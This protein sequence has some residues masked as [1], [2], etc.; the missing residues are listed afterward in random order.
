MELEARDVKT[1][2]DARRIVV[3]RGLTD[4]KL[5][6]TDIDGVLR[7]KYV[8]AEKF[9][10][11]LDGGFGFCDVVLGWDS[12][13]Q[14]VDNLK[15]TGWHTG[16]PDAAVRIVPE[17]CRELPLEGGGLMFLCEFAGEGAKVCPRGVLSRVVERAKGMG[18]TPYAGFEYEFF[19][20]DETPQSA[21]DKGYQNLKPIT[22]GNFG[23]SVLRNSVYAELYKDILDLGR[24]MDFPI[25]G[26]HTET[27]PGVLEAAIAVDKGMNP[28]DKAVLFKSFCKVLLNRG[29]MMPT[30]MAKY[31]NKYAGQSGH[32]HISLVD[33]AGKNVFF[34]AKGPHHMSAT[35]RHFIGGQQA[36][37]PEL[38]VMIASTVN[39]YTRLV[40]GYWAPTSATWAIDNR[41]TALRVIE[42]SQKSQ[43]VEFRVAA[44]DANPYLA[45]AAG[46]GAGLYGIENKI[47]PTAP[48]TGNAYTLPH[49]ERLAF[50]TSLGD[51]ARRFRE[52][53][54]ARAIFGEAF[55]EHFA[56]TRDWEQR[57]FQ[58]AVT[59]WE[60]KR[61]F[62]I[63]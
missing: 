55:V 10:S 30:F 46:I 45:L 41:T 42:G 57:E 52:S 37:M 47:E 13:D 54:A 33:D 39:S 2:E 22:P 48:A 58:K 56:A 28:A 26:L 15:F 63:I 32:I 50:P 43:R 44:A 9:F 12:N 1:N 7:G 29:G 27:G 17:T 40:P 62:E 6:V 51:A 34:D 60:L 53:K 19:V 4:V 8:S 24:G 25:E 14:L 59:D 23:Y 35:Q 18:L 36:L 31:S 5:A 49:D 21:S 11:A 16:F 20:F 38:L 3:E 61:Y